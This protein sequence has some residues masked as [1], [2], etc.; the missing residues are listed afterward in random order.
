MS[1]AAWSGRAGEYGPCVGG[2]VES[3]CGR[4][5]CAGGTLLGPEG[6][7]FLSRASW[8]GGGCR[9]P[10]GPGLAGLVGVLPA[11]ACGGRLLV[12]NC[13][14]DASILSLWLFV[15]FLRAHG[16]CLGTRNRRRT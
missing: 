9:V 14:V 8:C 7:G 11:G 1:R 2:G 5:G 15:K 13:T 12:E 3:W 4:G 10:C 16:G 6:S